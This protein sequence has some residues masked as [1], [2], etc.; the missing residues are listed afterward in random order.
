MTDDYRAAF[1][2]HWDSSAL[3][4]QEAQ[5]E[6]GSTA[7]R[8]WQEAAYLA[9]YIVECGTKMMIEEAGGNPWG[10]DLGALKNQALAVASTLRLPAQLSSLLSRIDTGDLQNWQPSLRYAA[11]EPGELGSY[12]GVVSESH[13]LANELYVW[14]TR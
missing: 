14:I 12:Q 8:Y 4:A 6:S 13:D 1:Y 9:G 7:L 2:R 5:G 10:H 11:E 3:L